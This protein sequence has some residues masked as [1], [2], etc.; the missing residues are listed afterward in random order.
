MTLKSRC[1]A[2]YHTF[3]MMHRLNS[4]WLIQ[5]PKQGVWHMFKWD[6]LRTVGELKAREIN[7]AESAGRKVVW[8][9]ET[10]PEAEAKTLS[11]NGAF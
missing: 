11:A 4:I 9:C 10:S 7:P 2:E 8:N 5:L 6:P 3:S 1:M